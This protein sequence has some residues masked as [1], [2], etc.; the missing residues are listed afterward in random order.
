MR[1]RRLFRV[2]MRGHTGRLRGG[3][4]PAPPAAA[5]DLALAFGS[6]RCAALALSHGTGP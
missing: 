6:C 5:A 3:A 1:S 2:A 4:L